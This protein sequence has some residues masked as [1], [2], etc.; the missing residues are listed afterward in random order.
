MPKI[1]QYAAISFT[2]FSSV[3][4][5]FFGLICMDIIDI[6]VESEL[7][8]ESDLDRGDIATVNDRGTVMICPES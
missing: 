1:V 3:I 8:I 4:R 7:L 5:V 2:I 6:T